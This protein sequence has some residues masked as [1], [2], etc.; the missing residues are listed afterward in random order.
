MPE[1]SETVTCWI[2]KDLVGKAGAMGIG[3]PSTPPLTLGP[4][5]C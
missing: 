4:G 1:V 3:A 5:A 2:N